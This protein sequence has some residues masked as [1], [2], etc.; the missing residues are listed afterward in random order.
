MKP[1][2]KHRRQGCRIRHVRCENWAQEERMRS[3]Q[4]ESAIAEGEEN[5]G[6]NCVVTLNPQPL[7]TWPKPLRN[8]WVLNPTG[9]LNSS[10][11][12]FWC[13]SFW[14][15]GSAL[16]HGSFSLLQLYNVFFYHTCTSKTRME[17]TFIFP[18]MH[19]EE[20]GKVVPPGGWG[21]SFLW[22]MGVGRGLISTV[23]WTTNP[24]FYSILCLHQSLRM[25]DGGETS[26]IVRKHAFLTM[27]LSVPVPLSTYTL[28]GWDDGNLKHKLVF[29][30][31]DA[32]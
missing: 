18:G 14:R 23:F 13:F 28:K 3:G 15:A 26:M 30:S 4:G 20:Q 12:L 1:T 19:R 16:G 32:T 24:R 27:R 10:R 9:G 22:G 21:K 5:V 2:A 8:S 11:L 17:I 31:R 25:E 7:P 29:E 6:G